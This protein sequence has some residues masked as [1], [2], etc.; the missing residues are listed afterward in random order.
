MRCPFCNELNSFVKDSRDTDDHK[1]IRRRRQCSKCNGRFT[2]FER[3]QIRQ[4]NV[5][6]R[7][8][9]IKRFD[10]NKIVTSIKTAMRKR[11]LSEKE[12]EKIA[13]DIILN[14][15]STTSHEISTRKIGKL[16]MQKLS[17]IDPVAYIRFASVYKDFSTTQDFAKFIG[18]IN[19]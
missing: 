17:Q 11:H 3:I 12:I 5:V 2:T 19:K 7:S 4:I 14:I 1:V 18:K 13:N 10:G 9:D 15:E 8:G 16:I 6:K